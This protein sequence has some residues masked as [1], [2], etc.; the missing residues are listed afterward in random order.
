MRA[1][2]QKMVNISLCCVYDVVQSRLAL[3]TFLSNLAFLNLRYLFV[4]SFPPFL[5]YQ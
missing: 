3:F 4:F 5:T 2:E 1:K